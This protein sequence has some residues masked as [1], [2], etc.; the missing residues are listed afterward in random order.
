MGKPLRKV[1]E[2]DTAIR[3]C[4]VFGYFGSQVNSTDGRYLY[5]HSA[6]NPEV[7]LYEYTLMPAHMRG[8]FTPEE[9]KGAVLAAPFRFTKGC[10]VLRV[11]AKERRVDTTAFG[12]A[13]YDL[14]GDC[15]E[16]VLEAKPET[17]RC[18]SEG[19]IQVMEAHDAPW[20]ARCRLGFAACK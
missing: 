13:L 14:A 2:D 4:A 9:L 10:P 19:I 15:R 16:N 6:V 3:S 20:E 12:S 18:L 17:V 7:K 8:M 11:K 5:M 1:I